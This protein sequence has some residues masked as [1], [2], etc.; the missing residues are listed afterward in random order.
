M[1]HFGWTERGGP[2]ISAQP[3]RTGF[4]ETILREM[5]RRLHAITTLDYP[6][7]GLRYRLVAPIEHISNIATLASASATG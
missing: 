3:Q 6:P 2:P 7:E 1:F 5:P 4:G